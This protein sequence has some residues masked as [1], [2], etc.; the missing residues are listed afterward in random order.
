M[1]KLIRLVM[2]CLVAVN[3]LAV[4]AF[5]GTPLPANYTSVEQE[6]GLCD[7]SVSYD[8]DIARPT[9]RRGNFFISADVA[10]KD[11]GKGDIIATGHAYLAK[12]VTEL[13]VSFYLDR[14]DEDLERWKQVDCR[15]VEFTLE[16]YPEG[17][18][19]PSITVTFD[20]QKKG[21]YYR[22]RGAFTASDGE[23]VEGFGP[24]T[25]GIWIE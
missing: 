2:C 8:I 17:I 15:D 12:P 25:D 24:R 21:Y 23:K 20:N 1:K 6:S 14:Y 16:K 4:P 9:A 18:D 5:A 7:K 13:Y 10:I 11:G 19:D 22:I 3:V